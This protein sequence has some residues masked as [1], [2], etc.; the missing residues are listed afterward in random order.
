[1]FALRSRAPARPLCEGARMADGNMTPIDPARVARVAPHNL[2]AEQALIGA[3]LV[4]NQVLMRIGDTLKPEHFYDPVHS[5]IYEAV[6][7][8]ISRGSLADG[9]TLHA[10]FAQDGA[11]KDIGG[12]AYLATLVDAA[13]DPA[14]T[15]DYA[16]IVFDHAVRRDLI[17]IGSEMMHE[18]GEPEEGFEGGLRL[19]EDAE[20]KLYALAET[21]QANTGFKSFATS[22]AASID[23][24]EAAFKRDGKLAG[25]ATG[26][27]DLDR[28]LGGLHKSDLL[29]LAG[30]P[31]MGKS[32]L[33]TNIAFNA[34]KRFRR[35][36][37]PDGTFKTADGAVVALYSLEMSAEQLTMRLL[38]DHTGVPSDKMRRGDLTKDEYGRLREAAIE[39]QNLPLYIDDTGGLSISALSA[40]ARRLQRQHGLDMIIVDYLQLVTGSGGKKSDNRVQEVSEIT[41]GLKALAKELQVPVI[42]LSQLSRQ[43]ENR[44]DKRPQLSDLRESG[45]IEQDADVV[46]FVYR[47]AYYLERQEPKPGSDEH[48]KWQEEVSQ[49]RNV[50]EVIIGKQRH[51]PIGK[52]RLGF[53][54]ELTK[55]TNLDTSGRYEGLDD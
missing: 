40:R 36:A 3:L 42:A 13:A 5:R 27:D 24:A 37:K 10:K 12:A 9:I 32:A 39:L 48:F 55:F 43:V 14:A 34:A 30:R 46:M 38:A 53:Q 11:L 25:V 2:D 19:I 16:K 47:H 44:E 18:A 52:V 6:T 4:D 49:M 35:E 20:K 26:L 31:S 54:A 45:S 17:R 41:Q 7:R 8:M 23:M 15:P 1:M 33:A 51:G 22:L 29:I 28:M 21:G 50:A